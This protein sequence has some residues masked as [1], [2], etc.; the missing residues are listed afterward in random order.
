MIKHILRENWDELTTHLTWY[1]YIDHLKK[2]FNFNVC[3]SICL[4]AVHLPFVFLKTKS[5]FCGQLTMFRGTLNGAA[6]GYFTVN[7]KNIT[8][9]SVKYDSSLSNNKIS[10][11]PV[12]KQLFVIEHLGCTRTV[13]NLVHTYFL[14]WTLHSHWLKISFREIINLIFEIINVLSKSMN[15]LLTLSVLPEEEFWIWRTYRFVW[16]I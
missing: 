10:L 6:Q 7:E 9:K 15:L 4:S 1:E 14:D 16:Y 3:L 13:G 11:M 5:N 8:P 12:L 2:Y